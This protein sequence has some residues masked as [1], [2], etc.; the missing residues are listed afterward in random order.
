MTTKRILLSTV[1]ATMVLSSNV[2][3]E[4]TTLDKVNVWATE[5]ESSSL[6]IDGSAIETKQSDHLSDLLSS[7]PGVDIGGTHSINNRI[8]IRGLQDENLDITLDGAKVQNANMFHHIG[9]LLINPDILKKADVQ[10]GANSVVNGS[11]G[12][13]VAFETKD[14][15]DLLEEGKKFGARISA[16]YNSNDSISGSIAGYGKVGENLDFMIYHNA[17]KKNN[18]E[19]GNGEEKFAVEGDVENTLLKAGYKLDDS[20]KITLSYDTVTDEGDYSPRPD[21]GNDWNLNAGGGAIYPTR[22]DRD[23]ITLK[24]ELILQD[25][26]VNTSIYNNKNRLVRTET[27]RPG[28][29]NGGELDG[30]VKT[31]GLNLKAQSNITMGNLFN[32]FTYGLL[33][34]KQTSEVDFNG[35]Q[36][37]EDEKA[38]SKAIYVENAIDFDNGL[39]VTPGIRFNMYDYDGAYGDIDDNEVTYSLATE[40]AVTDTFTLLA[41]ATTLY[42][43]VEM[44]EV[45]ASTRTNMVETSDL[46]SETGINKEIG[47]KYSDR[48]ILGA[49]S[50]GFVFKYFDT[51]IENSIGIDYSIDP[52]GYTMTNNGDLTLKGFEASFSYNKGDLSTLLTYAQTETKYKKTDLAD[53]KDPGDSISLNLDYDIMPNLA[54]SWESL[55][56]LKEQDVVD[57][58]YNEKDSYSVHDIALRWAPQNIN[59]LTVIA[60]VDNIFDKAYISH[61]SEN[62]TI[63]G[64]NTADYE[65]GRNVKVTLAYKF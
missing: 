20:Q 34:D 63:K 4:N 33:Y 49:D 31:S 6:N 23:T 41:S 27:S 24:H 18:W 50:A 2:F 26:T 9:N 57:A 30:L 52:N 59:N 35:E 10:V 51:T 53:V 44:L 56:L 39:V 21:F 28:Y 65:P 37:G 45:L 3:A 55:F 64:Y 13:A 14:G 29:A 47:F 32:T 60:G 62:R 1:V 42:K 54:L 8:N 40:Y 5:I 19:N 43:G 25:T 38:I 12:G 11:L 46:K 36:Y 16:T 17:V 22:Y 15:E 58:G 7:L 48:E 61:I